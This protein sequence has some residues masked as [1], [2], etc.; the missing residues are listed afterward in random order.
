MPAQKRGQ[1][2]TPS[3]PSRN[4]D[5]SNS[6]SRANPKEPRRVH[7]DGHNQPR[8]SAPRQN[9]RNAQHPSAPRGRG[10]GGSKA[11]NRPTIKQS[12]NDVRVGGYSNQKTA[13][14]GDSDKFKAMTTQIFNHITPP[15]QSGGRNWSGVSDA[16]RFDAVSRACDAQCPPRRSIITDA[17]VLLAE[18]TSRIRKSGGHKKWHDS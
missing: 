12:S 3:G 1:S 7:F 5:I 10:R 13:E 17:H 4:T 15:S 18:T 6:N 11:S 8:P 16:A 2:K 14:E 9:P